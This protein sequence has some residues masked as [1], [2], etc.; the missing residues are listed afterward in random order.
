LIIIRAQSGTTTAELGV[1]LLATICWA[2]TATR[3]CHR[4]RSYLAS[5]SYWWHSTT[6]RR[7][8]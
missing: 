6:S 3:I 2:V 8:T 7:L 1:N 4:R 5:H